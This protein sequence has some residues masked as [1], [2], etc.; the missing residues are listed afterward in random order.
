MPARFP[1]ALAAAAFLFLA[2][3][4]ASC[5]NSD[6][7]TASSDGHLAAPA[8]LDLDPAE[9][10]TALFAAGCFWCAETAYEG[11]DGVAAVTS[12][13]TG[14]TVP[15]P[16][17]DE[18]VRGG[19]GHYEAVEVVYDPEQV[20]YD[21]LLDIFWRN[22]DPFDAGGQFCDRGA[23]YRAALF[24]TPEQR[25]AAEASK[26]AVADQFT[27]TIVTEILPA[28][29]FYAAEDYH[30]DFWLKDPDRYYSYRAGC[31]RD[32]RLEQI[33]GDEAGGE[34]THSSADP[35]ADAP[36]QTA[37]ADGA[38]SWRERYT[39]ASTD[40][41][42]ERLT[43]MQFE[44]TQQDGTEPPFRNAYWDEK[45]E[46]LYVDVVS[47]EPLFSS[48][49]KFASGTGWPS[50]TRPVDEDY[51][52]TVVDRSLG[53]TRIEVRSALADSHLGHVFEDGPQ[54]TGLRYCINS[55]ALRFIPVENLEEEGYGEYVSLF[56]T[57]AR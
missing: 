27:Q 53:M 36:A 54:P 22:V 49:D 55:A 40:A 16:S 8:S 2:L 9:A 23:S 32:E 7:A 29:P 25:A 52:E 13:F 20:S 47:G 5:V 35:T 11:V 33:W 14:G 19:T 51:V 56:Q 57:A 24:V 4:G 43:A 45:R 12:G 50:F 1:A 17:Y 3:T 42:R 44:V 38:P 41:L 37:S 18:V 48:T 46:G 39:P 21:R 15:D 26:A 31:L 28:G 30:Q 34:M 10:D 6:G